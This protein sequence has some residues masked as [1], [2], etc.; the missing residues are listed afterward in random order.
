[1]RAHWI[2]ELEIKED[3][4]ISGDGLHHLAHVVRIETNEELLLLNGKGLQVLTEVISISK[5]EMRLKFKNSEIET[6]KYEISLVLGM[7]KREALELTLK[8][9]VE[10]GFKQVFLIKSDYSQMKAP[11]DERLQNLLVSALE[12]SNAGHMPEVRTAS[13]ES[14]PWSQFEEVL[15]L[16]SQTKNSPDSTQKKYSGAYLMVVGPEGG[17]SPHEL[18]FLRQ[19]KNVSPINLPTPILRTPTAV[20]VGA[21]ILLQ[22]L[23]D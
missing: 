19:L 16:D 13:W 10:L 20:S 11:E 15:L 12:Q 2:P 14:V 3:Y 1:M 18:N 5:R 23:L 7:P 21:G 9:A 22:R 8:Q 17:F 6:R 4:V